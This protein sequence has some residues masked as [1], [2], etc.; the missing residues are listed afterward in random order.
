MEVSHSLKESSD[1]V[2]TF[3]QRLGVPHDRFLA[4]FVLVDAKCLAAI[5]HMTGWLH[6]YFFQYRSQGGVPLRHRVPAPEEE[7]GEGENGQHSR[8]MALAKRL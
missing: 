4:E 5:H 2:L 6:I 8:K 3:Y 1:R 7:R